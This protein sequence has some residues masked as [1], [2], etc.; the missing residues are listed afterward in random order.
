MRRLPKGIARAEGLQ[1]LGG[2]SKT[3]IGAEDGLMGCASESKHVWRR[4]ACQTRG[5]PPCPRAAP[6]TDR[7]LACGGVSSPS[8]NVRGAITVQ[9]HASGG[10]RE[11]VEWARSAACAATDPRPH[12][13]HSSGPK[14]EVGG[15]AAPNGSG[16]ASSAAAAAVGVG[17]ASAPRERRQPSTRAP[18]RPSACPR[19]SLRAR[20]GCTAAGRHSH[21]SAAG[22]AGAAGGARGPRH[23]PAALPAQG[24]RARAPAAAPPAGAAAAGQASA[25]PLPAHA[26][27]SLPG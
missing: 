12:A 20:S 8:I 2:R 1:E 15:E 14:Y 6:R 24:A 19:S 27:A 18:P 17:T 22:P 23:L 7:Q 11:N 26:L 10:R 9:R 5:R 3:A 13:Q 25:V 21:Q 16:C 4:L